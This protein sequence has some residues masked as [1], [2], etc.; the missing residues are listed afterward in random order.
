[1]HEKITEVL[2]VVNSLYARHGEG[3]EIGI[4]VGQDMVLIDLL[5]MENRKGSSFVI[6]LHAANDNELKKLVIGKMNQSLRQ[7]GK[8]FVSIEEFRA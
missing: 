3:L 2:M 4:V 1:M 6:D 5:S 8:F 7:C